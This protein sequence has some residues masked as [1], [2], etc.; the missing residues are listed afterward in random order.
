[1]ARTVLVEPEAVAFE[2]VHAASLLNVSLP[3]AISLATA[4][5]APVL[6]RAATCSAV[7]AATFERASSTSPRL[8]PSSVV[9]TSEQSASKPPQSTIVCVRSASHATIE[10]MARSVRGRS[11]ARTPCAGER[12]SSAASAANSPRL[13]VPLESASY[14]R[15]T[16]NAPARSRS[17]PT[18]FSAARSSLLDSAPER[19]LSY[20]SNDSRSSGATPHA[21]CSSS[22]SF[23][24]ASGAAPST[25]RTSPSL[26]LSAEEMAEQASR[27]IRSSWWP[28]SCARTG[29]ASPRADVAALGLPRTRLDRR[30][31]PCRR[32]ELHAGERTL[33]SRGG[34]TPLSSSASRAITED[35]LIGP[36]ARME[37][38]GASSPPSPA[39]TRSRATNA[40]SAPDAASA[41]TALR[42]SSPLD[43][44]S[45]RS[46][47]ASRPKPSSLP[48]SLRRAN[49]TS[50]G[51]SLL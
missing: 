18:S 32:D 25:A 23:L 5:K 21:L 1:M 24:G 41:A 37:A 35:R 13:S 27:A 46:Q 42:P 33:A 11:S 4:S 50:R 15:I 17:I 6:S 39:R 19:F 8:A 12:P 45:A 47:A 2:I 26:P 51:T 40:S 29:K 49:I 10:E 36:S 48:S 34:S 22:T 9:P 43:A 14:L 16:D 30:R 20:R 3:L 31:T 44:T 7:P 28:S 38:A